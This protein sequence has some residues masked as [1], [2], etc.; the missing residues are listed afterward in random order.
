MIKSKK[1]RTRARLTKCV[2]A[3]LPQG[4]K[5]AFWLLKITIPVSFAVFLFDYSGWMNIVAGWTSPLFRL[6]GL[7]GE[8]SI[9]LIT[10]IITN[11][12]SSIAVMTT[13]GT[14]YREGTILAVMC[15]ISHALIVETAIQKKTGSKPWRMVFT[16]LS[17]SLLAAFL[18]NTF[19]PGKMDENH[20]ILIK[21][22]VEFVPALKGWLR[23]ISITTLK[24]I[25][26]VNLLLIL[27]K[28]LSEFGLIKWILKP[29]IPLLKIMG[30][31]P[32]TGFLWM[33]AYTLGLSYGGA[34]MISQSEEGHLTNEEADLLNHHIAVS[35]SILEDTLLF[36]A[37]G[38]NLAIL[39]FPR[40]L[41]SVLYVWLRRL[42]TNIRGNTSPI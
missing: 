7:S 38:Y 6:I 36:A 17:A 29:F 28:I 24:I 11:I 25:V 3:A 41:L 12:Y 9:V 14:G 2:K 42:E 19:L 10:S 13:L 20:E 40:I 27:Q 30:L 21:Q 31:P 18:L 37:M 26:L 1:S 8:A 16:R 32:G 4:T 39:L 34:I 35:H 23:A 5:T 22:T 15:L 33:V